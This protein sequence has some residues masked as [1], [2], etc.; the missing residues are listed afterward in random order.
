[1]TLRDRNTLT[2]IKMRKGDKLERAKER[3]DIAG[4]FRAE[5]KRLLK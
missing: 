3:D 1:L 2:N 5:L 4:E